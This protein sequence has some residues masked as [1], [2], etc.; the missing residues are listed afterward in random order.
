MDFETTNPHRI[1]LYFLKDFVY[2]FPLFF[3]LQYMSSIHTHAYDK[4]VPTVVYFNESNHCEF[5]ACVKHNTRT[6]P[7]VI[8]MYFFIK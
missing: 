3:Y 1:M 5:S 6:N 2:V 4:H 7:L 8:L